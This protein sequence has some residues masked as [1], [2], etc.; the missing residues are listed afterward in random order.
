MLKSQMK[1]EKV[2]VVLRHNMVVDKARKEKGEVVELSYRDYAYLSNHDRVADATEENIKVVR[3]EIK[4][5]AA[6]AA[7]QAQPSEAEKLKD[8]IAA[9]E[10]E[11]AAAKK[12][13]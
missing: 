1:P 12:A 4:A 3:D 10:V 7:R 6:L 13:K 2:S 11:L 8:R 5:E 9:L